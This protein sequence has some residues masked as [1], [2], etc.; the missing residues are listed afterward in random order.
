MSLKFSLRIFIT[1][2][3]SVCLKALIGQNSIPN[4]INYQAVLRDVKGNVIPNKPVL[5][6]AKI[7]TLKVDKTTSV[8]RT[9]FYKDTSNEFGLINIQ[10]GNGAK[11]PGE[12][13]KALSEIDWNENVR[14]AITIT[15]A[16]TS[17]TLIQPQLQP[18]TSVPFS[19]K[20]RNSVYADTA[21]YFRPNSKSIGNFV[22]IVQ[23]F[24]A[25]EGAAVIKGKDWKIVTRT[26]YTRLD[27][28]FGN[29]GSMNRNYNSPLPGYKREYY[30]IIR[31]GD[32][33]NECASGADRMAIGS[34]WRFYL[35]WKSKPGH[36]FSLARDFG[37]LSEGNVDWVKVPSF[38]NYTDFSH[39]MY[40]RLEAKINETCPKSEMRVYSIH[41]AAYDL[42][43]A[44]S[45]DTA[46]VILDNT[47][48]GGSPTRYEI[49]H[50][51]ELTTN[52]PLV[53]NLEGRSGSAGRDGLFLYSSTDNSA[54]SI[55]TNKGGIYLYSTLTSDAANLTGGNGSFK[56][57]EIRGGNDIVEFRGS[58]DKLNPGDLVVCNPNNLNQVF[59]SI[60]PY[61]KKVIG[62]VSGAGGIKPGI[63]L[64]QEGMFDGDH[65]IAIAGT[66]KVKV[67]GKIE[68]GDLLTTSDLPGT[69]MKVTKFKKALGCIFGKALESSKD[70]YVTVLISQN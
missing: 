15:D 27:D 32:N 61:D 55:I 66:V 29:N 63:A 36:R 47:L 42:P 50:E 8:E 6:E 34:E 37:Y 25:N 53:I 68:A 70:G 21:E 11:V 22:G 59:K 52:G 48:A 3:L 39:P 28:M 49:G 58:N 41:V 19:L 5:I 64:K 10:I 1:I 23:I 7:L 16:A 62:V 54:S 14:Y 60:I 17:E 30:L 35:S 33:V 20:S 45:K 44:L 2:V 40:W 24:G 31:K 51:A 12:P 18:F 43:I 4:N 56:V 69:A 46:N 38:N 67:K 13:Y 26:I 9:E 65:P 57:L